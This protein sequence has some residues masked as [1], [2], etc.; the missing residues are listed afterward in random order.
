M[1]TFS[2]FPAL[3]DVLP[4]FGLEVQA[5]KF[6]NLERATNLHEGKGYI[7]VSNLFGEPKSWQVPVI[8]GTRNYDLFLDC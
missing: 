6:D 7:N 3:F 2:S 8:E 4:N 5:I 1:E